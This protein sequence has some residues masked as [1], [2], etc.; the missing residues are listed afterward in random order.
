M[1]KRPTEEPN[2]SN[3]SEAQQ[4]RAKLADETTTAAAAAKLKTLSMPEL[5]D[6]FIQSC[7]DDPDCPVGKFIRLYPTR[8]VG[9][10]KIRYWNTRD[11]DQRNNCP[12]FSYETI[13]NVLFL[14]NYVRWD[15]QEQYRTLCGLVSAAA[16]K[17]R[18]VF[19]MSTRTIGNAQGIDH[20]TVSR[21]ARTL[22]AQGWLRT[23]TGRESF[24]AGAQQA[25]V[26]S[27]ED[28]STTLSYF[29]ATEW[30]L[31]LEVM[32]RDLL[33]RLTQDAKDLLNLNG[34]NPNTLDPMTR[35]AISRAR[36]QVEKLP[37]HIEA[38]VPLLTLEG[39]SNG[40]S[41]SKER[42]SGPYVDTPVITYG[43]GI[44]AQVF[45]VLNKHDLTP[46]QLAKVLNM[47]RTTSMRNHKAVT[48]L[49]NRVEGAVEKVKK[50]AK[51]V[52][53]MVKTALTETGLRLK[54]LARA[55]QRPVEA[56]GGLKA[57]STPSWPLG[58]PYKHAQT[59]PM[60]S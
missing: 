43:S 3:L 7:I 32:Q 45:E 47:P 16:E 9:V 44:N 35:S 51:R 37:V 29:S 39:E 22:E 30:T 23:K 46:G 33:A 60:T 34:L 8:E 13:R 17:G 10:K 36:A 40:V 12:Q 49:K 41:N 24:L 59:F 55:V 26:V 14:A 19:Q 25:G 4:F 27:I 5:S 58:G 21:Q 28:A 15:S 2:H 54:A 1:N 31:G 42:Y 52:V 57:P 53:Q 50:A 6:Q 18:H 20:E 11:R 56:F 48:E 38:R